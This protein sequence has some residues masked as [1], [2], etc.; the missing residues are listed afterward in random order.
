LKSHFNK[1]YEVEWRAFIV[2]G[3]Q[4]KIK[5]RLGEWRNTT[6]ISSFSIHLVN[7]Y[8]TTTG[9]KYKISAKLLGNTVSISSVKKGMSLLPLCGHLHCLGNGLVRP[10]LNL[11]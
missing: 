9:Q 4:N 11:F 8:F 7:N 5:L 3:A 2:H 6:Y 10:F 1:T